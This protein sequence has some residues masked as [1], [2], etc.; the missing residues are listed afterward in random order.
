MT[1][2]LLWCPEV[3]RMDR[4]MDP[5]EGLRQHMPGWRAETTINRTGS[6]PEVRTRQLSISY[7]IPFVP[8]KSCLFFSKRFRQQP[9][10]SVELG[11]WG[12]S[13][14]FWKAWRVLMRM[15]YP[16]A[17]LSW[18]VCIF[19]NPASIPAAYRQSRSVE[20]A[21]AWSWWWLVF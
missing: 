8:A 2:R 18:R 3:E 7:V 20:R 17:V 15:H 16:K 11:S 13:W 14:K 1:C 6:M 9:S 12:G 21:A 5:S 4:M 10:F 19:F